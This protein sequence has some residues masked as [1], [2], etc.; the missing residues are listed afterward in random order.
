[1]LVL[2]DGSLILPV[3]RCGDRESNPEFEVERRMQT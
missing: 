2:T 3:L 1:V